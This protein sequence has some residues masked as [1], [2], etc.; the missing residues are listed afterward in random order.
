MPKDCVLSLLVSNHFGVL[1]RVTNLFSRRGFNIKSL[2]VG[3]TERPSLS[4]ITILTDGDENKSDQIQ[5]Q[6]NK[7]YDVKQ[8]F[9]LPTDALILRE[10]LLIKLKNTDETALLTLLEKSG[11]KKLAEADSFLIAELTG[12][13]KEID[14]FVK[15]AE[16]FGILEMCRT[17]EA[18]LENSKN[19]IYP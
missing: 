11:A 1:T 9:A 4:R 17:G 8:T 14:A 18:A 6:L 3:E 15:Q 12:P 19:T 10:L 5:K 2:A 16:P 7:L 13:R